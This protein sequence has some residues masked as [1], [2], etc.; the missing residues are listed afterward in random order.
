MSQQICWGLE[1]SY[2]EVDECKR[3]LI[4]VGLFAKTAC[5]VHEHNQCDQ[6]LELKKIS[7][8]WLKR[9]CTQIVIKY[10]FFKKN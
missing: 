6:M 1:D 9:K 7:Q 8:L 3:Y 2:F 4:L 10:I 5:P